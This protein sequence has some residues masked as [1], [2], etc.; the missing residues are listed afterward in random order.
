MPPPELVVGDVAASQTCVLACVLACVLSLC[1]WWVEHKF[2]AIADVQQLECIGPLPAQL[3]E[4]PDP[5]I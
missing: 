3:I 4:F 2:S 1:Q 5:V